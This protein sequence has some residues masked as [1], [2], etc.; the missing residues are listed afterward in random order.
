MVICLL[1]LNIQDSSSPSHGNPGHDGERD[2][3][4]VEWSP[5]CL[6][7]VIPILS[8]LIVGPNTCK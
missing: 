6:F 2:G 3:R 8:D 1:L 5:Y 4:R 7:S